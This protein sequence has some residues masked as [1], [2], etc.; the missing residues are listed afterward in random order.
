MFLSKNKIFINFGTLKDNIVFIIVAWVGQICGEIDAKTI[1]TSINFH[2]MLMSDG[3][4]CG[5]TL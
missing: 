4:Y 1:P 5:V 2:A 3:E